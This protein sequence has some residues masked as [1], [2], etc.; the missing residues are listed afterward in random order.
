MVLGDPLNGRR[1]DDPPPEGENPQPIPPHMQPRDRTVGG[2]IHLLH[3]PEG[4]LAKEY[5]LME[6]GGS[7]T[8]HE[9]LVG[10]STTHPLLQARCGLLEERRERRFFCGAEALEHKIGPRHLRWPFR[11]DADLQPRKVLPQVL[12]E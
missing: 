2:G 1:R 10:S 6:D 5:G 8:E 3:L 9:R 11:P 4:P 12:V 7:V